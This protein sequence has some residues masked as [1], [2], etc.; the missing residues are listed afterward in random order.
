MLGLTLYARI[1]LVLTDTGQGNA[2]L[3]YV[4]EERQRLANPPKV[5]PPELVARLVKE[6]D[7]CEAAV[8]QR[9]GPTGQSGP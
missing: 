6:L 9:L 8:T 2:A 7:R 1:A 4:R 3:A 5:L